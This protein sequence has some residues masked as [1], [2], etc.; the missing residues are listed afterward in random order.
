MAE[1]VEVTPVATPTDRSRIDLPDELRGERIVLRPYRE[2]DAAA[3]FAAIEESREHLR[4]WVGW[5]DRY[6]TL[7]QTRAYCRRCA[8]SWQD[9]TDLSTGIFDAAT[10]RLLGGA[11]LHQP[12]WAR[13]TFEISC[14]LRASA[15]Y[16][17]YGTEA[18]RLLADLAFATLEAKMIKLFADARNEPTRRLAA[19]CGYV[20]KGSVRNGYSAPDGQTVDLL[21]YRLTPDDWLRERSHWNHGEIASGESA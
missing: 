11:G 3:V 1:P 9:R 12:N 18:L 14:W 13:G 4:P 16:R 8:A 2:E 19:K 10:A 7:E 5:V 21:V 15:A 6:T 17:G 20:F